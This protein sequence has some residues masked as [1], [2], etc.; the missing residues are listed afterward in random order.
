MAQSPASSHQ[1]AGSVLIVDDEPSMRTLL[2]GV[3]KGEGYSVGT[4]ADGREKSKLP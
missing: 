4:A 3:L 2:A 1:D